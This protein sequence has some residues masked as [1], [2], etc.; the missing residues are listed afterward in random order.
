MK[1]HTGYKAG[2]GYMDLD[3]V[4]PSHLCQLVAQH[5]QTKFVLFHGGFPWVGE[6]G[7]IGMIVRNERT[8]QLHAVFVDAFVVDVCLAG[9]GARHHV[10]LFYLPANI[11]GAVE[12]L[13]G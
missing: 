11:G 6:T 9:G 2:Y 4:R 1:I 12:S 8:R 7:V 10:G 5:P 3:P 13:S